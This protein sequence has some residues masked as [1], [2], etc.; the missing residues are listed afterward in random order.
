MKKS[1]VVGLGIILATTGLTA[2][3][4]V[5][6][7]AHGYV[8]NPISRA[9]QGELDRDPSVLGD[10]AA[11]A[12]YGIAANEPQSLEA[13]KGFPTGGPA[14]GKIASAN[15][16]K[17]FE[18]D[19]QTETL[20]TRQNL[21][22]GPT[23]FTWTFTATHPTA[24]WHYYITKNG[25]NPNKPLTRSELQFIGEVDGHGEQAETNPTHTITIPNDHLGYHVIL[26][27]WDIADTSNAFYNVIDANIQPRNILTD[28]SNNS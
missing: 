21:T 26:A 20:W 10:N 13:P 24:K 19:K 18:L 25:W 17:G 8:A 7:S 16:A 11:I 1:L 23:K 12:K 3:S 15:G 6:V 14:D 2:L 4:T 22:T 5:D 9:R 27:V 28:L